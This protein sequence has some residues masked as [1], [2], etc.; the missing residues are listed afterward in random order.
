[1][2]SDYSTEEIEK[3][4]EFF[5]IQVNMTKKWQNLCMSNV[6]K[7]E[8]P[9]NS[10]SIT[11][12]HSIIAFA[13]LCESRNGRTINLPIYTRHKCQQELY[14]YI[15]TFSMDSACILYKFSMDREIG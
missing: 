12:M 5:Q 10:Y 15:L 11:R 7:M 1:M 8:C 14:W 13:P 2:L 6:G 4:K 9:Y 3:L